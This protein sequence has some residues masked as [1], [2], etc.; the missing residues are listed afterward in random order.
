[1]PSLGATPQAVDAAAPASE[2]RTPTPAA[3]ASDPTTSGDP[4]AAFQAARRKSFIEGL[5]AT[6]K[7]LRTLLRPLIKAESEP[8]RLLQIHDLYRRVH[9]L[10][11]NA[12]VAGVPHVARL[13]DALEAL[14]KALSE[15]PKNIT[16]SAL[17]TIA[18]AIDFL[19]I[20]F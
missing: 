8:A 15:Q 1:V 13:S 9:A 10:T 20:L 11:G 16:A 19:G 7:T 18:L 3:S 17:R 6:L 12:G 5:P 4:D 14:L 2:A